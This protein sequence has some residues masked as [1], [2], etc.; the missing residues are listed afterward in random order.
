MTTQLVVKPGV[1]ALAQP[2]DVLTR[3]QTM[4]QHGGIRE[5]LFAHAVF[6]MVFSN[7]LRVNRN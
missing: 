2:M 1:S 4:G 3:H 7:S 6:L 5:G